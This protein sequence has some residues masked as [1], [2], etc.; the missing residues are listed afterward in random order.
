MSTVIPGGTVKLDQEGRPVFERGL[1]LQFIETRLDLLAGVTE[2]ALRLLDADLAE[3]AISATAEK[4]ATEIAQLVY[5]AFAPIP[6]KQRG[7]IRGRA[8]DLF[9]RHAGA[10][11]DM[12][13]VKGVED[14]SVLGFLGETFVGCLIDHFDQLC[15]VTQSGEA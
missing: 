8:A 2:H 15:L 4:Q 13:L 5:L 11:I 12:A 14:E 10:L 6:A 7:E 1:Y 3:R 9:E